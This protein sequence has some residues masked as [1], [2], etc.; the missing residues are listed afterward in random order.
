[1]KAENEARKL[2]EKNR[3]KQ[4]KIK[5]QEIAIEKERNRVNYIERFCDTYRW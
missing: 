3:L 1:M 5:N 4:L 2:E